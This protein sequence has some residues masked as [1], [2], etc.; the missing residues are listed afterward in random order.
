M[1][2]PCNIADVTATSAVPCESDVRS[3]SVRERDLETRGGE[4]CGAAVGAGEYGAVSGAPVISV[5]G[6]GK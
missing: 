2:C 5:P 4:A 1:T 6:A 3:G